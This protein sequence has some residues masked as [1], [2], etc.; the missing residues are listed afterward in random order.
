VQQVVVGVARPLDIEQQ[1]IVSHFCLVGLVH[2][3]PVQVRVGLCFLN[4]K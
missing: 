2:C 3:Y 1:T 4:R